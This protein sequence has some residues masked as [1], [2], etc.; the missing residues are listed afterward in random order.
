MSADE[1]AS[2]Y[3]AVMTDLLDRHC[4]LIT[5]RHCAKLSTP[6]FDFDCRQAR[7]KTRA[8]ERRYWITCT[9]DHKKSWAAELKTLHSLYQHKC[10]NFWQL[11]IEACNDDERKLWKKLRGLLGES[12]SVESSALSTDDLASFFEDRVDAV[13]T[14]TAAT[15]LCDVPCRPIQS[16]LD[17]WSAV[18]TDEV[19]RLMNAA[20]NKTSQLDPAS[21]W[22]VKDMRGLLS[23][24]LTLLFNRSLSTGCFPSEFK[25]AIVRPL[26]K[27]SGLDADDPKNYRPVST[28]SFLSKLLERIVQ[29]QLQ[30]YFNNND[31]SLHTTSITVLRFRL[32]ND[33]YCVEWGVKLYSLTVLRQRSQRSITTYFWLLT[34]DLFLPCVCWIWRLHSTPSTTTYY[35]CV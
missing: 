25:Q 4:P 17:E 20:P 33:L 24:F 27:K 10:D 7:R 30:A 1:L 5:A 6:W 14:S 3:Q 13:R 8:A 29:R 11:E 18:T 2:L 28:L 34:V 16:T 12:C 26:L 15:P 22:L 19:E 32:R 9:E 31:L 21:M 35:C 23:P